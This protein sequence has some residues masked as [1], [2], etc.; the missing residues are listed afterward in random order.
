M[1]GSKIGKGRM[2]SYLNSGVTSSRM[3]RT[4]AS[5]SCSSCFSVLV[6]AEIQEGEE[7][8]K[9]KRRKSNGKR[10]RRAGKSDAKRKED[11]RSEEEEEETDREGFW[12]ARGNRRTE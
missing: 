1:G 4:F 11:Q 9:N 10:G 8:E 7:R 5:P 6:R 2:P 12:C 3:R